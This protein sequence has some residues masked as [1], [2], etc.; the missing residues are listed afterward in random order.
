MKKAITIVIAVLC[1]AFLLAG[2][3][4]ELGLDMS[5]DG[6]SCTVTVK[7]GAEGDY[8]PSGVLTFGEGQKLIMEPAFEGDGSI[9]VSITPASAMDLGEN[10]DPDEI[11]DAVNGAGGAALD[12]SLS[13]TDPQEFEMEPG[14]YYVTATVES[15]VTGTA[16]L[17]VADAK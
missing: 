14:D 15:K 8:A 12:V 9:L 4:S 16:Q 5:S 6:K 7:N 1:M 17:K 3:K 11:Q 2:C 13:G 10:A